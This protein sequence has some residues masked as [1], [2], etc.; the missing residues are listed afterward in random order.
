MTS[1]RKIGLSAVLLACVSL[2]AQSKD[3]EEG[4]GRPRE[5]GDPAAMADFSK[6]L[7][8]QANEDQR[9]QLIEMGRC[10]ADA[11]QSLSNTKEPVET[12]KAAVPQIACAQKTLKEFTKDLTKLQRTGLKPQLQSLNKSNGELDRAAQDFQ[13]TPDRINRLKLANAQFR[14]ALHSVAEEMGVDLKQ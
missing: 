14:S 7:S 11:D 4:G 8:V 2:A 5:T 10:S 13:P 12:A 3:K 1:L 6:A 9:D